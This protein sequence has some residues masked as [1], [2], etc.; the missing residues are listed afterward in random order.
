MATPGTTKL[1]PAAKKPHAGGIVKRKD[2]IHKENVLEAP[3]TEPRVRFTVE[4]S[5]EALAKLKQ[6]AE[7]VE[8][9]D[10][11]NWKRADEYD[12]E[13]LPTGTERLLG[14]V[15]THLARE[16]EIREGYGPAVEIRTRSSAESDR[17]FRFLLA[18]PHPFG[19]LERRGD[20]IFLSASF[21]RKGKP[22]WGMVK[23]NGERSKVN[24]WIGA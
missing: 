20:R 10:E 12:I 1:K 3:T 24:H 18:G 13:F 7:K 19:L 2:T 4:A 22:V 9:L 6:A 14:D 15:R 5:P 8:S 21:Y 11:T 16:P 17:L 23:D